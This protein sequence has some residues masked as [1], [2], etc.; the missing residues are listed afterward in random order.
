MSVTA[1]HLQWTESWD[2]FIEGHVSPGAADRDRE[3]VPL[4][5]ELLKQSASTGMLAA[6]L[7]Q[8]VGGGGLDTE[9]W[10]RALERIGYACD[11]ASFALLVSLYA[12]VANAVFE[13][14]RADLVDRYVRPFVAG[15]CLMS[16]AYTENADPFSF[17]STVRRDGDQLVL[18]GEK[19]MVTGGQ[20]ADVFVVY[21]RDEETGDL[22]VVMLERDD[23][24]VRVEPVGVMGVRS[25]GLARLRFSEVRVPEWRAVQHGDGLSHVQRFLNRRRVILCSA[26]V[27]RMKRLVEHVIDDVTER[28]RYGRRV[29]DMQNV[30][31]AVGRMAV[32]VETAKR[33]L[34]WALKEARDAPADAHWTPAIAVAKYA[35]TESALAVSQAALRITGGGGYTNEGRFERDVRDFHALLAGAGAQDILEVDLGANAI[36]SRDRERR[37]EE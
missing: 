5:R 17:Q 33:T 8:D 37:Y 10:G 1:E 13:T 2:S 12:G 19:R 34:Y 24:G 30:Q 29:A 15:D 23:A 35:I 3:E 6:S 21:V 28:S 27:G 32:H 20:Q 7:P 14:G 25:A 22:S 18:N 9:A 4:P 11:D 16:F 31:A 26:V 36:S